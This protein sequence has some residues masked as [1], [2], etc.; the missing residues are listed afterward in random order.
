M[1]EGESSGNSVNSVNSANSVNE[2]RLLLIGH[3]RRYGFKNF[4][5]SPLPEQELIQMMNTCAHVVTMDNTIDIGADIVWN[6][7][8]DWSA[9][10]QIGIFENQFDYIVEVISPLAST[11]RKTFNYWNGVLSKMK[12]DGVYYG[13]V[14]NVRSSSSENRGQRIAVHGIH[15][16]ELEDAVSLERV[17]LKRVS[18]WE[19]I[20]KKR[21]TIDEIRVQWEKYPHLLVN[22]RM[23]APEKEKEQLIFGPY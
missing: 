11:I 3:G 9:I 20:W 7:R 19:K 23:D 10:P 1:T 13:W 8:D 15:R 12:P 21:Q 4:R 6:V 2:K 5:C 17:S 16:D 14:D 18:L 22:M